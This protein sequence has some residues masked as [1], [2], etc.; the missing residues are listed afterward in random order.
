MG[1]WEKVGSVESYIAT[2]TVD[3]PKDKIIL[4]L[5]DVFGVQL[6]NAQVCGMSTLNEAFSNKFFSMNLVAGG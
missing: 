6:I 2:P 1:T 5:T 3:Y 4:F